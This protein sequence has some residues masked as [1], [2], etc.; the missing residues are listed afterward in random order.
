MMS[1][2]KF[3]TG[4]VTSPTLLKGISFGFRI[5]AIGF[6]GSLFLFGLVLMYFNATGWEIFFLAAYATLAL[7]PH[8][9]LRVSRVSFW[10]VFC[11][12]CYPLARL[13]WS[14]LSMRPVDS[15]WLDGAYME[16]LL[17][18]M[19]IIL[20]GDLLIPLSLAASWLAWSYEYSQG[21]PQEGIYSAFSRK[22]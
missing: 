22:P 6:Y 14:I 17:L 1:F 7:I 21:E 18:G 9:W 13:I 20:V 12:S 8:C 5:L 15:A 2:A 3:L 10:L 4:V 16:W 11:V 19:L